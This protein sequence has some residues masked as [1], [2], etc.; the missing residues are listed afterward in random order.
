[1]TPFILNENSILET[2]NFVT[3]LGGFFAGIISYCYTKYLIKKYILIESFF[4]CIECNVQKPL[5][6]LLSLISLVSFNKKCKNC[7]FSLNFQQ[8]FFSLL[9]SLLFSTYFYYFNF[10]HALLYS[11]LL[12]ILSSTFKIDF[13][14]M[15]INIQNLFFIFILGFLFKLTL[16]GFNFDLL[17]NIIISFL[18]GWLI[19]FIISFVYFYVRGQE[20]FGSG[21]K[22]LL[23]TLGVWYEAV[24]ILYLFTYSCILASVYC[25]GIFLISKKLNHK[26]P[27]GA[28]FCFVSAIYMFL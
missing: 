5:I 11:I 18:I 22:W 23:G 26:L 6:Q 13:E 1:M 4:K 2:I 20:G 9:F 27:I 12:I 17:K 24:D 25:L 21:D 7:G 14:Y 16:H 3:I 10:N 28:F 19:I 15:I 8:L